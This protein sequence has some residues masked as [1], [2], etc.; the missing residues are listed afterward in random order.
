M[1]SYMISSEKNQ[2]KMTILD[3]IRTHEDTT[4]TRIAKETHVSKATV[5]RVVEKLK[6]EGVLVEASQ[7][8]SSGGR[9][10][11]FIEINGA[12][13]YCISINI[14]IKML[15]ASI[16]DLRM[17]V[18]ARETYSVDGISANAVLMLIKDSIDSLLRKKEVDPLKIMGIGIGVPGAVDYETGVVKKFGAW[19]DLFDV[20]LREF[21]EEQFHYPVYIDNIVNANAQSEYWYGYGIGYQNLLFILCSEGVGCSIIE[22]GTVFHGRN[23]LSFEF[24]HTSVSMDN[25]LCRCGRR[26][27]VEAYCSL[28][29]IEKIAAE[30]IPQTS[31]LSRDNVTFKRVCDGASDGDEYCRKVLYDAANHLS[32][33]I[34]NIAEIFNPQAIIFSG[35]VISES[36]FFYDKTKE[37]LNNKFF[38]YTQKNIHYFRRSHKDALY[39]LGAGV[40]VLNNYFKNV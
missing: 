35:K 8:Q 25:R 40:L 6:N 24:G 18:I 22:N 21:V 31:S 9:K 15:T 23:N 16:I 26:G 36:D 5:T 34:A 7:G 28:T 12:A 19:S 39:E 32:T 3:Y 17:R 38:E 1:N 4:R 27:C 13:G 2:N 29:S 30:N 37:L 33:A 11:V 10:P 14:T 20:S